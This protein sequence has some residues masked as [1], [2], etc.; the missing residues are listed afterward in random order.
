MSELTDAEQA[1]ALKIARLARADTYAEDRLGLKLHPKQKAVLRDLFAKNGSRVVYRCSNEVGKTRVTATAAILF[2]VEILGCVVVSTAGV[3]R[4]VSEQLIPS[5]KRFSHLYNPNTWQFLDRGIKRYDEKNKTWIDAYTGFSA[6]DE[7][8]FQGYHK[9]EGRPLL[10][11]ID[12]SQGVAD[13]IFQAAEDRCNPTYFIAM[14]SPGDPQGR[15]YEME[16]NL[17]KHYT[18]HK[19]TRPECLTTDGWWIEP[20]D[21]QR[22]VDK[23]GRDNPF[24]QSTVF[25]EFSSIVADAMISLAEYDRCLN[26]PPPFVNGDLHGFCDFAAGRDKN[27]FAFRIGNK[28]EIVRKWVQRDT[29]SAVGEFLGMFVEKRKAYGLR[30]ENVSGDADGLGLPMV[31]R[32]RELDWPINEFH[33]GAEERFGEGYR[34]K[35][36]EAWGEGIKKIKSCAVILPPDPDLKAQILGRKARP[37]SSGQLEIEKKE[38]YKKRCGESPDEA[39]AFFGCLMPPPRLAPGMFD[40]NKHPSWDANEFDESTLADAQRLASGHRF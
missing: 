34:N 38:D 10:I 26:N 12:E 5:L 32:M 3:F 31:Q 9:D 18:H 17:A 1:Q 21:I 19:L 40:Q 2:A 16:T 13:E 14:G 29:M 37:N 33:G 27:C 7:N 8:Y 36:A 22:M 4:Q 39:D 28:V 6:S 20:S 15:F 24:V 11:I 23:Y 30:P 25:G 35:I